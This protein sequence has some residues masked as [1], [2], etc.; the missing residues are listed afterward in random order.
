M[1]T[2]RVKIPIS[3]TITIPD[4]YAKR[5]TLEDIQDTL[6]GIFRCMEGGEQGQVEGKAL[7]TQNGPDD[8][9]VPQEK[10][11]EPVF[12]DWETH[13]DWMMDELT[14]D[15]IVVADDEL[16]AILDA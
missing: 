9:G 16:E 5:V 4:A 14:P 6:T 3:V 8:T 15:N 10:W 13:Y 12:F 11:G 1:A 7:W 2:V